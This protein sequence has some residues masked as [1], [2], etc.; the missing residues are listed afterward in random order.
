MSF[1][2]FS[3]D[4]DLKLL[5]DTLRF[6]TVVLF[7]IVWVNTTS[8]IVSK[9][10]FLFTLEP[11]SAALTGASRVIYCLQVAI[12]DLSFTIKPKQKAFTEL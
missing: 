10:S 8:F 6:G 9:I 11:Q 2:L 7:P 3:V 12:S 4:G 5:S 1:Y